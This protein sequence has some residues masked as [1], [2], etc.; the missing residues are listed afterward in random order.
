M[1]RR[2]LLLIVVLASLL[3]VGCSK[4]RQLGGSIAVSDAGVAGRIAAFC[5]LQ[6]SNA[7]VSSGEGSCLTEPL[8]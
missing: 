4:P 7:T 1:K 2:A 3:L 6:D 8:E 5:R